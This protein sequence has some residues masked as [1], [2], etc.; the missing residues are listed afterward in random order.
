[1]ITLL[2]IRSFRVDS[3]TCMSYDTMELGPL[4]NF[5]VPDFSLPDHEN[6]PHNLSKLM[7]TTGLL[8][9]FIG[10][11]WQPVSVRRIL[12]LQRQVSKLN[13]MGVPITLLVRDH[14]HT[15]YGFRM[16]SPLP[17][18]FPL[19]ADA[20]G[21]I[22]RAYNLDRYPGLLLLDREGILRDKW[23]M[24]DDRVWPKI[25]EIV[26]AVHHLPVYA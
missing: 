5:Q 2:A 16:S 12:W 26:Q 20:D 1:M 11:I 21:Q 4:L 13:L 15:L 19:L 22:H 8:M 24:P 17:V 23:L 14:P 7:G 9:G 18:P 3:E 25:N 10:D 6:N